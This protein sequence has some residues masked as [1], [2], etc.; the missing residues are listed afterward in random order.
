MHAGLLSSPTA[1]VVAQG[2]SLLT[3]RAAFTLPD[4]PYG[5][6]RCP[7]PP[8]RAFLSHGASSIRKAHLNADATDRTPLSRRS[9]RCVTYNNSLPGL[10]IVLR[11]AT[12]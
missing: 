9:Q 3:T 11:P 2:R 7:I 1:A 5:T 4:L 6:V 12:E 8:C 10:L